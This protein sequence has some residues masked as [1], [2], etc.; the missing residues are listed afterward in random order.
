MIL[1]IPFGLAT[2]FVLPKVHNF[3]ENAGDLFAGVKAIIERVSASI[4]VTILSKESLGNIPAL[5]S[6]IFLDF[7]NSAFNAFMNISTVYFLLF[8]C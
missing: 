5:V 1:L 2:Y 3:S 4:G 7:L 6:S 8:F